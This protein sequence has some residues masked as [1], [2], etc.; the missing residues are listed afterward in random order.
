MMLIRGIR[1]AVKVSQ[2][3]REKIFQATK[4]LLIKMQ[5]A[6]HVKPESIA[7]IF[8]TMTPDLNAEFPACA[9]RE[10]GWTTVPLLCVRELDVPHAMT[11]VIRALMLVNTS[12]EQAKIKHQ[13]LGETVKLRPDLEP[14]PKGIATGLS[15]SKGKEKIG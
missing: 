8:L 4:E 7:A 2:N 15:M 5:K 14:I 10:L 11:G 9:A 13:Y 3:K 12:K 6:N 1:G